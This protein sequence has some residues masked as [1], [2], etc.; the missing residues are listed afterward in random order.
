MKYV[1][2]FLFLFFSVKS[3]NHVSEVKVLA[4]LGMLMIHNWLRSFS[5]S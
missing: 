4:M 2:L 5:H 3:V 1:D